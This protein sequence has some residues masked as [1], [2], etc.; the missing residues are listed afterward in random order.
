MTLKAGLA[1]ESYY[2]KS[3]ALVVGISKYASVRWNNLPYA[4]SDAENVAGILKQKGFE[5][6]TLYDR[7]ATRHAILARLEKN[8]APRLEPEDR[9]FFYFSGHGYYQNDGEHP[10]TYLIP[11]DKENIDMNASQIYIS[12]SD[13][14]RQSKLMSIAKHQFFL[15][16]A[17]IKVIDQTNGNGIMLTDPEYLIKVTQKKARQILAAGKNKKIIE[18]STETVHNV[19]SKYFVK[20]LE[21]GDADINGDGNITCLELCSYI[22]PRATNEGQKPDYATFPGHDMGEFLFFSPE[23]T[24]KQIAEEDKELEIVDLTVEKKAPP[25]VDIQEGRLFLKIVPENAR[26]RILNIVPPY[27]YGMMLSPG[28]YKIEVSKP[29][30]QTKINWITIANQD[31][32]HE[33]IKLRSLRTYSQLFVSPDPSDARIRIMNIV[34]P[35]FHG[36]S[37]QA[38]RYLIEVDKPG[39]KSFQKWV[40]I[41]KGKDLTIAPV[42]QPKTQRTTFKE[43]SYQAQRKSIEIKES[44]LKPEKHQ[45]SRITTRKQDVTKIKIAKSQEKNEVGTP[46]K[47][48]Q[49]TKTE[50]KPQV[51]Q[52]KSMQQEDQADKPT[53][54]KKLKPETHHQK[55]TDRKHWQDK[56]T[57]MTF[58]FVKGGCY[59]MGC[60]EWSG[61]C[62]PDEFPVHQVCVDDFWIGQFEV[63]Q[64]EW[65]IIMGK[66]PSMSAYGSHYP[67]ERVSWD[68]IQTFISKLEIQS[69]QNF[70]LPTEAEWEFACRSGGKP[71]KY[72]GK[73]IDINRLGWFK[74][75]STNITHGVGIKSSN[76]LDLF[77]MSGN[78]SEWCQDAYQP[79]AYKKHRKNKPLV[80]RGKVKVVRGGDWSDKFNNLRCSDR[81]GYASDLK[82]KD[83]GFRLIRLGK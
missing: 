37:L 1:D 44:T 41:S 82:S 74:E 63:T 58:V 43:N 51:Q 10:D 66:N 45:S 26:I 19:L 34:P 15:I 78:V 47:P 7:E 11:Y 27:R 83:L 46:P 56:T 5:V 4:R 13:L 31:R 35:Y 8:I 48:K 70:R 62:D 22:S 20:G 14:A 60:G 69:K 81:R 33:T 72:S 55:P 65:E 80:N 30:Y 59:K 57:G 29:G 25:I 21:K 67:V 12:M 49:E 24:R 18:E 40:T 36:M 77:D 17:P 23:S 38:G 6:L 73:G 28:N 64:N 53:D 16:D 54:T 79:K 71:Q 2:N 32:I 68:D 9:V 3:Y 39:Y 76:L 42:L 75:N 52:N 61:Q 50:P